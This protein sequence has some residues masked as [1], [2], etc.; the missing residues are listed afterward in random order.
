MIPNM[1]LRF[2]TCHLPGVGDVARFVR[3]LCT[4]PPV[5]LRPSPVIADKALPGRDYPSIFPKIW[6]MREFVSG[7]LPRE[8]M[9]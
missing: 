5:D 7:I 2:L 4:Q 9:P 3:L 8:I 6:F 1:I